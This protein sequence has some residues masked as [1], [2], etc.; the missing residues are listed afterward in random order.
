VG[1]ET[2]TFFQLL[3]DAVATIAVGGIKRAVVAEDTAASGNTTVAI[4]AGEASIH[5]NLLDAEG[6]TAANPG[7]IIAIIG[8]I[9]FI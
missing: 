7:T 3:A 4:G 6:E 5:R 1:E 2:L 8:C 9:H